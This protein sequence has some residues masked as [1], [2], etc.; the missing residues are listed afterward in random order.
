MFK[1][2]IDK[3]LIEADLGF[4]PKS[5]ESFSI[6]TC[7]PSEKD[8][9]KKSYPVPCIELLFVNPGFSKLATQ[10]KPAK[11]KHEQEQ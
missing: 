3:N 7:V 11:A 9:K 1:E 10:A 2:L 6:N 4:F 5:T 8:G